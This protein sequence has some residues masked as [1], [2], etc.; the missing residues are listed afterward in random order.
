MKDKVTYSKKL[1][2]NAGIDREPN[3][4]K[5]ISYTSRKKTSPSYFTTSITNQQLKI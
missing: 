1:K 5:I 3:T 2:T 4:E